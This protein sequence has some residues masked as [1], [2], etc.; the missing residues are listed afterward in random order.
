[1]TQSRH[2]CHVQQIELPRPTIWAVEV[3]L[4]DFWWLFP[5]LPL[6]SS[7]SPNPLSSD[8]DNPTTGAFLNVGRGSDLSSTLDNSFQVPPRLWN[9]CLGSYGFHWGDGDLLFHVGKTRLETSYHQRYQRLVGFTH[10]WVF[11]SLGFL[12]DFQLFQRDK[13]HQQI[14]C[15][16]CRKANTKVLDT[17][18]VKDIAMQI[19]ETS[20]Q[21]VSWPFACHCL[22]IGSPFPVIGWFAPNDEIAG[23]DGSTTCNGE[24]QGWLF[25]I[26][27]GET[28]LG[29]CTKTG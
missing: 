3:L 2:G 5:K 13:L 18:K 24:S 15:L 11:V 12:N 7:L 17:L 26:H 28:Q 20:K 4:G 27:F 10:F 16:L 14:P 25:M 21:A 29:R 1:M 9:R 22:R 8:S 23:E 6:H 19:Y